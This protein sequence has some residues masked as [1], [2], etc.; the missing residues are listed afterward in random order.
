MWDEAGSF[1][2]IHTARVA[3][4]VYVLHTFQKKAQATAKRDIFTAQARFAHLT[5]GEACASG[6]SKAAPVWDAQ[7]CTP[8]EAAN[9]RL[10]SELLGK[11]A[12][13]VDENR[14][15]QADAARSSRVTQARM[16]DLLRGRISRFSLG[17]LTNIAA[18]LGRL[19]HV[20]L[21]VA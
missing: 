17:A 7:A 1:R 6:R 8:E 14:S 5:R 21:A 11:I 10:R 4:A 3:D 9:L 2:L 13:L 16:N 18:S 12:A 15:T 20:E 19:V